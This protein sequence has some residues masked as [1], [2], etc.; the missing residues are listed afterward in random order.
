MGACEIGLVI[1]NAALNS[2]SPDTVATVGVLRVEPGAIN[3]IPFRVL[4]EIDLR[5]TDLAARERVLERI[6]TETDAI[7]SRRKLT[8]A[9][10]SINADPPAIAAPE[11]V[12]SAFRH[13]QES[14]FTV[15]KMISRAYHDSLFMA[16]ICPT[17][18]IFIP[19]RDGVS[20]RP[21]EY[22]SPAQIAAGIRMLAE[23]LRDWSVN[24]A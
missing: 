21:D 15:R 13:A 23:A 19:C 4:M 7:C 14:G 9:F 11:L 17:T 12:D 5:D 3:S 24:L 16:M 1:E 10:E 2:G 8:V 6:R 18:M 20:H 22:S